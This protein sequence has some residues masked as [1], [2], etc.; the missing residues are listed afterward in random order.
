[1]QG[2]IFSW[3]NGQPTDQ[4]SVTDRALAYGDGLFETL[5]VVNGDIP[6][7]EKH[8]ARL[9]HGLSVLG[10]TLDIADVRADLDQCLA[11]IANTSS[12]SRFRIK[13]TVS[14]GESLAGY[15]AKNLKPNRIV[16]L[17]EYQRDI[18]K[19]QQGVKLQ[20]CQW[21]L[22]SQ[23][24]LAGIKHLNRLDQVMAAQELS[25]EVF[26]G[27]MR[28]EQGFIIEGTMSNVFMRH[29]NGQWL[30]PKLT[31]TGV[32]GVMRA[33]VI[34]QMAA[35][36]IV[37]EEVNIASLTRISELFICNALIGVVPVL[38]L[39]GQCF[40]IGEQLQQLQRHINS[41]LQL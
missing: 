18:A 11:H 22:S 25:I 29:E 13:Y 33:T 32:K 9:A 1:M 28:D 24:A 14:R 5:L 35:C 17:A 20:Y 6:L 41:L 19:L 38:E 26:D 37:L 40:T 2:S 27:L 36:N 23:G 31:N 34:E 39:E 12:Q 15:R 16:Q 4:V 7:L 30:T 21:L 3:V 10:I 8:L